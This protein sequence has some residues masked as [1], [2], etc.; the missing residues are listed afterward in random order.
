METDPREVAI[1]MARGALDNSNADISV[2]VTGIAGPSGGSP[3]KPVG[4]V[5][6]AVAQQGKASFHNVQKFGNLCRQ[7]IRTKSTNHA[8]ELVLAQLEAEPSQLEI[9]P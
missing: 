3:D 9:E 6:F 2:A 8:L 1:A 4:L 7:E 5:H